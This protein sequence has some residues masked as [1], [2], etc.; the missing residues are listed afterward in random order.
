MEIGGAT[1][2]SECDPV[3]ECGSRL[4]A[5]PLLLPSESLD[6][7]QAS[8]VQ[9]GAKPPA[10]ISQSS[11]RLQIVDEIVSTERSYMKVLLEIQNETCLN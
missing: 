11:R 7:S 8:D 3:D 4:S 10:A 1:L 9:S 5:R 6:S 2:L